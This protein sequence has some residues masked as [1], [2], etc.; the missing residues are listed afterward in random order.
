VI[1]LGGLAE[2][3]EG[4]ILTGR[5]PVILNGKPQDW[6]RYQPVYVF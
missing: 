6:M 5:K 2:D 1:M 4:P 3:H